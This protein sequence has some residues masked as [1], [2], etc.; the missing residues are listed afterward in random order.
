MAVAVLCLGAISEEQDKDALVRVNGRAITQGEVERYLRIT[1]TEAEQ[2]VSPELM[3]TS[4]YK[5]IQARKRREALE[6]LIQRCLLSGLAREEY[7]DGA[8]TSEPLDKYAEQELRKLGQKAG[9]AA[10]ARQL[11]AQLGMSVEEYKKLQIENLLVRQI[12]WDKVH[13]RVHVSPTQV[14]QHYEE[15]RESFRVPRTIVYRQILFAVVDEADESAERGRAEA[16]LRRVS[17]GA[18]FAEAADRYSADS[19]KYPGGLREVKVPDALPDWLP[20][21]VEGLEPGR[22]SEVR[23]L[24]GGFSIAKLEEV[25][26]AHLMPFEQAQESI[27]TALLDRK[28]AAAQAEYVNGLREEAHIEYLPAAGQIGLE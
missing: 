5:E 10:K 14:R 17:G 24:A 9:S 28:R 25:A 23:R 27:K 16:A 15:H 22:V 3:A 18:D 4:V 19:D 1:Q 26:P 12:L 6:A 2:S 11:L 7:L 21:A 8:S 13:S 20:P